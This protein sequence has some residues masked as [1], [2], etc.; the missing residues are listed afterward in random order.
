MEEQQKLRTEV[1]LSAQKALLG[2]I[3]P[4]V[5]AIAIGYLEKTLKL[6]YY[7]EREPNESDYEILEEVTSEIIADFPSETFD[8]I[9]EICLFSEKRMNDLENLN[10]WIYIRKEV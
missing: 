1:L 2:M 10:G 4:E 8:H 9:E 7:L 5:R 3:Y 6:L